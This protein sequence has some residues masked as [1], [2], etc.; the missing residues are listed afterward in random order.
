MLYLNHPLL[1]SDRIIQEVNLSLE[2]L[3]VPA[4]GNKPSQLRLF[5]NKL[6][7]LFFPHLY[8]RL[9]HSSILETLD[10]DT[11]F[12]DYPKLKCTLHILLNL[13]DG[14]DLESACT[15]LNLLTDTDWQVSE[16]EY[17]RFNTIYG[18][19]PSDSTELHELFNELTI[20]CRHMTIFFEKNNFQADA[21]AYEYAHKLMVLFINPNEPIQKSKLYSSIFRLLNGL[22]N[23]KK[24]PLHEAFIMQF[25]KLPLA[26]EIQ[27]ILG[28]RRLLFTCGWPILNVWNNAKWIEAQI[29]K[30][31]DE[32]LKRAPKN[33]AEAK[34]MM[35]Y[36]QYG[37][38]NENPNFAQLCYQYKV[39]EEQ[40]NLCLDLLST[41]WPKKHHDSLPNMWII[42]QGPANGFH[43]V[44]LPPTDKRA[45]ILGEI[46]HCCQ[47]I[48]QHSENCVLDAIHLA[49][50]GIYV[51]LKQRKSTY[52]K[53]II[54][55]EINELD[56]KIVGQS[57]VWRSFN[58]NLCLDSIE[59]LPNEVSPEA[60]K[61]LLINFSNWTFFYD[62]RIRVITAGQGGKT[63]HGLFENAS[64]SEHMRE[65]TFC[66]DS[67]LQYCIAQKFP[68]F[69]QPAFIDNIFE[70]A[71]PY[72]KSY[73]NTYL[74]FDFY[75]SLQTLFIDGENHV[76]NRNHLK[77]H[78]Q[79]DLLII[80]LV[81]LQNEGLLKV[82]IAQYFFDAL[83]KSPDPQGLA[84]AATLLNQ[85]QLLIKS[86]LQSYI[87]IFSPVNLAHA[88]IHLQQHKI[89]EHMY[90]QEHMHALI[91]CRQPILLSNIFVIMHQMG[92]FDCAL[93]QSNHLAVV[94][95]K[96]I[97]ELS[98]ILSSLNPTR[99]LLKNFVQNNFNLLLLKLSEYKIYE[100]L[101]IICKSG[102]FNGEHAQNYFER[103]LNHA[104]LF[105]LT[106]A[107]IKMD[108]TDLLKGNNAPENFD[109]LLNAKN[110]NCT[111]IALCIL[112]RNRFKNSQA[113][114]FASQ[115][116]FFGYHLSILEDYNMLDG[117]EAQNHI[118]ALLRHHNL[119]ALYESINSVQY[120][121]G[122]D[123]TYFNILINH[124]KIDELAIL[125]KPY[126]NKTKLTKEIFYQLT[127]LH[128]SLHFF[129]TT[130]LS[131][132]ESQHHHLTP[133]SL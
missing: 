23:D 71:T 117:P 51:L 83:L 113:R 50:N 38:A 92:L 102:L 58:H 21:M 45:L 118:D 63:P 121:L 86:N 20:A 120:Y 2:K 107:I 88:Q 44:K 54:N 130:R 15:Q 41:G 11:R 101:N 16:F 106:P 37:R 26:S 4:I 56:F 78:K 133:Q 80:A 70:S 32:H 127:H 110:P 91:Q 122:M 74:N 34:L 94:E 10:K 68:M 5:Q 40:F 85:H 108:E 128:R 49:H 35:L 25:Y 115:N 69:H 100:A 96:K 6:C 119:S 77:H 129:A 52:S 8:Q 81:T 116:A 73:L 131:E 109:L 67:F 97:K 59:C 29:E 114:I 79:Q 47:S 22:S 19:F 31:T 46:T 3:K 132:E 43:W 39:S 57:Y 18:Y 99:I 111:A 24:H 89:H 48:G 76:E 87:E 28:W 124:P 14:D 53:P 125:L 55:G 60:L 65:G 98:K 42:G 64:I 126:D 61:T 62:S 66:T 30:Q 82:E 90:F 105:S 75:E 17:H 104:D 33:L 12:T 13:N 93:A 103:F 36:I 84:E 72:A 123:E 27:D 9:T 95:C 7:Q 112:E 1:T